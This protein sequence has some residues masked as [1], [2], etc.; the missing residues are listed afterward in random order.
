MVERY[1][2]TFS[3]WEVCVIV[4][5]I[6]LF[7]LFSALL[8]SVVSKA[9]D[10][11]QA[12]LSVQKLSGRPPASRDQKREPPRE[13]EQGD[14]VHL[15]SNLVLV[16]VS[17]TDPAGALVRDLTASDFHVEEEGQPQEPVIL[18]GAGKTPV[19]LALLFD[20]SGSVHE[21]FDF[22][23]QAASRFLKTVLQ[24]SDSAS[25][26][27]I[28]KAPQLVQGSTTDSGKAAEGVSILRPTREATAFYRTVVAAASYLREKNPM[29]RRVLVVI[30]DGED[31]QSDNLTWSDVRRQLQLSDCLFYSINPGGPSIHLNR[32]SIKGQAAMAGLAAET[33]GTAFVAARMEDLDSL[34]RQISEELRAQYL[35]GYYS[36]HELA[37][38]Q[39]RR[40]T[41]RIPARPALRVRAKQGY[42]TSPYPAD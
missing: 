9:S 2:Q 25:V 18:G 40:I 42:F 16:P 12:L 30:S 38:G 22:E 20:I 39:F 26:F 23:V 31:N 19:E 4:L 41:V 32:I 21:R 15:R 36:T 35:L 27:S 29:G 1:H 28:G 33:G 34:F 17:V 24:P 3:R 37:D 6:L 8:P 7:L 11:K 14:V 5:L 10:W 13:Q